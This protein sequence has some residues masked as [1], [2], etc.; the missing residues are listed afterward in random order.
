MNAEAD[1]RAALRRAP[2]E[3]L[4]EAE[5]RLDDLE[6]ALADAEREA[7]AARLAWRCLETAKSEAL[8]DLAGPVAE[9]AARLL[10][11]IAGA[12]VAEFR[13][14][15]DFGLSALQPAGTDEAVD[16]EQFSGGEQEQ[17]HLAVRLALAR[18][19]TE[20]ERHLVVLD[21][22]LLSTDDERLGRIL[23]LLDEWSG[24]MQFL[25]LTC[26]AERYRALRRARF[27]ELT[28]GEVREIDAAGRAAG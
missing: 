26:H 15:D 27:L 8:G 7:E 13:L 11:R 10:A 28:G 6:R 14:A 21:D 25:I 1:L 4:A 2:Y 3:T 22:V 19:L 20:R 18:I 24:R 23:E 9:E 5:E 12:S 16:A 17:I